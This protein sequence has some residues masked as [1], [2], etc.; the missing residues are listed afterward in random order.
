MSVAK[1]SLGFAFALA[2]TFPAQFASQRS[3]LDWEEVSVVES[4]PGH[5]PRLMQS[6][7]ISLSADGTAVAAWRARDIGGD[8]TT[9]PAPV[10]LAVRVLDL[11]RIAL[12]E[13]ADLEP[14]AK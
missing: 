5:R 3:A 8:D 12:S 11:G 7:L 2:G 9:D 4:Q 13:F 14:P 10:K 1:W 6:S